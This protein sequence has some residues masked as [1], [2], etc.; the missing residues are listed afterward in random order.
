MCGRG[1]LRLEFRELG[2]GFRELGLGFRERP[3]PGSKAGRKRSGAAGEAVAESVSFEVENDRG[4]AM[5]VA[6]M[7]VFLLKAF[8]DFISRL[9]G[10]RRCESGG[11]KL[12]GVHG[13]K[14]ESKGGWLASSLKSLFARDSCAGKSNSSAGPFL[15]RIE[16]NYVSCVDF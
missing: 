16:P 9:G 2:L 8:I 4:L 12:P 11:T 6:A 13:F 15:L 14:R 3:S 7:G 1:E 10:A 5:G